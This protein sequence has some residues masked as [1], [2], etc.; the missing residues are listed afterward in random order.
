MCAY[1]LTTFATKSG[2]PYTVVNITQLQI[3]GPLWPILPTLTNKNASLAFGA[4]WR[5]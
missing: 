5:I 4:G 3:G 2:P 1:Q